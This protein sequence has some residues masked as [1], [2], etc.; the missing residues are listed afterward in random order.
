MATKLLNLF[1]KSAVVGLL[2]PNYLPT[3]VA[4][5]VVIV[6]GLFAE[7]QNRAV[8]M[9]D[10]RAA[11][12]DQL[13]PIRSKLESNIN[14]DIQ[15]VRG[16]IA[17]IITEP[18]MDQARFS[19][20]A[21]N[22]LN[23]RSR[24]R[25]IAAAPDLVVSLVYPMKGNERAV[26]LDYRRNENQRVAALRARDLGQMVLAGPLSL[27]QGGEGLIGRLIPE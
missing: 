3:Y 9:A 18:G 16:V 23:E 14:G 11:V 25:S 17:T 13:N 5:V 2:K 1:G 6:A 20:L 12:L 19:Q 21:R 4:L 10:I 22:I 26:G 7:E 24:L 15:L 8:H 27:V